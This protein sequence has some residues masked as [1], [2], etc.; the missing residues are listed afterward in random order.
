MEKGGEGHERGR[1]RALTLDCIWTQNLIWT[2][3]IVR[4]LLPDVFWYEHCW[5]F[6]FY[7]RMLFDMN[8]VDCSGSTAGCYLVW[9]VLI[10]RV[11]L[12]DV[13]WYEQCWFFG[14]YCRML[15]DMDSVYSSGSTA[16][17]YLI[18]TVLIFRVLLPDVIWYEQC[19]FFGFYCRMLFD[20]NTVDFL[21]STAGCYLIWTVLFLRVLLPD[22]I[23]LRVSNVVWGC[24][25]SPAGF[26]ET[27]I[28]FFQHCNLKKEL[29]FLNCMRT[30][31]LSLRILLYKFPSIGI[32]R[33][34]N[35]FVP[36][37]RL[38][39]KP[40]HQAPGQRVRRNFQCCVWRN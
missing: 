19:W 39:C 2:V 23:S 12:P 18:W 26:V 10:L 5:F 38:Y 36:L 25:V 21:G 20:M 37:N 29:K 22:V 31:R 14:F 32:D 6:G 3:L 30:S 35:C 40:R 33:S 15:F 7:C 11:L 13:I 4:V 28:V 1:W 27:I 9:R 34:M 17:C 8:S 16:G 24:C